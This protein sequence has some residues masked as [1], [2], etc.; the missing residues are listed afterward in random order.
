MNRRTNPIT[1]EQLEA[2]LR[3]L[4]DIANQA[5]SNLTA[6]EALKRRIERAVT[7]PEPT[8]RPVYRTLVPA[9]SL[10]LVLAIGAAVGI[11]ALRGANQP[12]KIITSQAAG[13]L[14][15]QGDHKDGDFGRGSVRVSSAEVPEYRS[16]WEGTTGTFPL[17][18]VKGR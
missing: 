9:L 12:E 11:P 7:N 8:R 18:G 1:D 6:D 13:E 10:A 14:G 4:P 17:I 3:Q 5:L 16:L 15:E 2:R